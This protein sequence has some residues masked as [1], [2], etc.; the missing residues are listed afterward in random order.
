MNLFYRFK[1]YTYSVV[2]CLAVAYIAISSMLNAQWVQGVIA[3]VIICMFIAQRIQTHKLCSLVIKGLNAIC[4][5]NLDFRVKVYQVDTAYQPVVKALNQAVDIVDVMQRESALSMAAI[6]KG[7]LYR[8]IMLQGLTGTFYTSAVTINTTIEGFF[9]KNKHLQQET[10]AFESKVKELVEGVSQRVQIL[11]QHFESVFNASQTTHAKSEDVL[12]EASKAGEMMKSLTEASSQMALAIGEVSSRVQE[13]S[14]FAH[15]AGVDIKE[16]SDNIY[17]LK[18]VSLEINAIIELI[19]DIAEQTNLLALNATIEAARAGEYGKSFSI[20]ANEV[21]NL[22]KKTM[23]STDKIVSQVQVTHDYVDITVHS[24]QK[25]LERLNSLNEMTSA[26]SA[27]VE[28]QNATTRQ[29]SHNMHEGMQNIHRVEDNVHSVSEIATQT[30]E[31]SKNMEAGL[32]DLE[33]ALK[34]IHAQIDVFSGMLKNA[35]K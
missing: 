8:K 22:A 9:Q 20:V 29:I 19:T 14:S 35:Q 13:S 28:Q 7:K 5:G 17:K 26:V 25:V 4:N 18:N 6:S 2:I 1:A 34:A 23:E 21:K 3:C 30:F 15:Q 24:I 10:L 31:S 32:I 27:A 11:M 12:Q 16:A 33:N